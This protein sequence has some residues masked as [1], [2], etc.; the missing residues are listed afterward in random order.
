MPSKFFGLLLLSLFLALSSGGCSR[1]IRSTAPVILKQTDK[2]IITTLRQRSAAFRTLRAVTKIH[3]ERDH[4][5]NVFNGALLFRKPDHL[6]LDIF[7]PLG[8]LGAIVTI[9]Q[10]S[11]RV[12]VPVENTLI[13][14]TTDSNELANIIGAEIN[15]DDLFALLDGGLAFLWDDIGSSSV[16]ADGQY[17]LLTVTQ[18]TGTFYYWLE[19]ETLNP[20]EIQRLDR[21]NT[22][23]YRMVLEDY[24]QIF[25]HWRPQRIRIERPTTGESVQLSFRDQ[26]LNR[27][28]KDDD[29]NFRLP[30]NVQYL[31]SPEK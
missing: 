20:V 30:E 6:R 27:A 11:V 3:I 24:T 28:I 16:R 5:R 13:E 2:S 7:G 4:Q 31:I 21:A 26:E 12:Y 14:T 17:Y 19:P 10:D 15:F 23:I 8:I 29:F 1:Q 22:L 25:T 9:K 18:A